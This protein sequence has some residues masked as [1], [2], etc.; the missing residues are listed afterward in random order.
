MS[1][2]L[3]LL[4]N[5]SLEATPEEREKSGIL[6][7]GFDSLNRTWEVIVKYHGSLLFLREISIGVEELLAGYAIL[8][9][10]E[11]KMGL[12]SEIEEIEYEIGRAH[13]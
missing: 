4:L 5:A 2:K 13:V 8:T 6:Q 11:S 9:V 12:L 10:P 1:E 3:E 7:T